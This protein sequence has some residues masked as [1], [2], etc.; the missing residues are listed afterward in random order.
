[1]FINKLNQL[2]KPERLLY[3]KE[4]N[5][6]EIAS[7]YQGDVISDVKR[8]EGSFGTYDYPG[9]FFLKGK[10]HP[11]IGIEYRKDDEKVHYPED[12]DQSVLEG[13]FFYSIEIEYEIDITKE[14]I[15]AIFE[16]IARDD[17]AHRNCSDLMVSDTPGDICIFTSGEGKK[18]RILYECKVTEDR[19]PFIMED[20]LDHFDKEKLYHMAFFDPIT[21][22]SNWNHLVPYLEMPMDAGIRDYA[23]A[24]FDIKAF[25]VINELYGHIAANKVLSNVVRAMKESD[26]IYASARCHNDNFAMLLKDMPE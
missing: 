2:Y 20:A 5:Q 24:H 17:D 4:A 15:R 9:V 26:F 14:N 7:F 11:V 13:T 3:F 23:F 25:K 19:A 16:K 18:L 6:T 12:L 8:Y 10:E 1:M 22:H 21:G